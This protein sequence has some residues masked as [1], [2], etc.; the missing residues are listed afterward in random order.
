MPLASARIAQRPRPELWDPDEL[1]TLAEAAAVFFPDGPLSLSSLRTAIRDGDL[2]ITRVA[3]KILT[4]PRAIKEMT[5][6]CPAERQNRPDSI[7]ASG[8]AGIRS[9]SFSTEARKSAQ[10][11]G[12]TTIAELR[13]SLRNSTGGGEAKRQAK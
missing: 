13:A 3:G 8:T 7:S 1:M 6:P 10:N 5:K 9:G 12:L 11:A 2:A 4:T